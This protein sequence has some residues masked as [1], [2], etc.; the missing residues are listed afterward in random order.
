[1]DK[2]QIFF[3]QDGQGLSSTSANFVANN[4]KEAYQNIDSILENIQ[5]YETTIKLL[6]SNAEAYL[7]EEGITSVDFEKYL[8]EKAQLQSLIAWLREA[9]KAKEEIT[10]SI[11]ILTNEEIIEILNLECPIAPTKDAV[12]TEDEYL[13]S[14]SVKERNRYYWLETLCSVY[15]KFVH[16]NGNYANARKKLSRVLQKPHVVSGSGKDI[17]ITKYTPT[18]SIDTVDEKFFELQQ[19]Y[20]EYQAELNGMKH[21]MELAISASQ[22]AADTK[23]QKE[24][25][26]YSTKLNE[27]NNECVIYKNQRL[28][29]ARDL[30]III[31]ND[32]QSVY[33]KV[34]QMGKEEK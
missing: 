15:G 32:L 27:L 5:F 28:K 7:L 14:L 6:D 13:A 29:E 3:S 23:Y 25:A 34:S 19:K 24:Y 16:P 31:P 30:K 12:L 11:R 17:T 9:I 26:L 20:R 10:K 21:K 4:A 8:D 18:V 33:Q 2:N 22:D 1:M